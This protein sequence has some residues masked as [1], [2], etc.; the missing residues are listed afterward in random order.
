MWI[1]ILRSLVVVMGMAAYQAN[2]QS[3]PPNASPNR[4]GSGWQCDRG[5]QRSGNEC[6]PVQI[7]PNAELNHLGNGWQC[8]RGYARSGNGCA[9]VQV[10]ANADLNYLGSGWQCKRG[11]QRS[12]GTCVPVQVPQNAELNYIG[13][14]W[15]CKRGFSKVGDACQIIE[16]PAN[17]ELN[18]LGNG[19]SCKQGYTRDGNSCRVMTAEEVKAYQERMARLREAAQKRAAGGDCET[20]DQS[21]AEVCLTVTNI[22][23]NCDEAFDGKS[24]SGCTLSISYDLETDYRGRSSIDV[25]VECNAS[26]DTK[27]RD[28]FSGDES[29]SG[30]ESHTLYAQDNESGTMELSFNF[31]GFDEVYRASVLSAECEIDDVSLD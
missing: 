5:F 13:N 3:I 24:Y 9:T 7:P 4:Y 8:K 18:S 22:D 16:I 20:E 12:G 2:A 29:D 31:S 11:Y 21:G 17:A 15:Q 30:E 23:L 10:P 28:G 14:G 6:L 1:W 26:I 19:W 27:K 25:D